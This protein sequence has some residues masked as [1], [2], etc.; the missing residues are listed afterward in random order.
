M[1]KDRTKETLSDIDL[2]RRRRRLTVTP[3]PSDL[4]VEDSDEFSDQEGTPVVD[5]EEIA[6]RE[7]GRMSK[8][9]RGLV[10]ATNNQAEYVR[11]I[12]EIKRDVK[13]AE[14]ASRKALQK[15]EV[16]HTKLGTQMDNLDR[17]VGKVEDRG[18]DC[19]QVAAIAGLQETSLETR[20]K[21]EKDVQEGVKTRERLEHTRTDVEVVD[22]KIESFSTAKRNFVLSLIGVVIFG[23]STVGSLVWFLSSLNTEFRTE[24]R[25]RREGQKRLEEQVKSV[26]KV[27]NVA[28]VKSEIETLTKAVKASN[29]HETVE[30]YC[31]GL[32]DRAVR[33]MKRTMPRAEWPKCRRFGFEPP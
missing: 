15:V 4:K 16:V 30:R 8:H 2:D 7:I 22:K 17:R 21:V 11:Q 27:A 20:Q 31:A 13:A 6:W 28:P 23:L 25:E 12:P 3:P 29:G 32:S 19:A 5:K 9:L 14:V 18:H 33:M 24:Q 10:L 26:G 1:P